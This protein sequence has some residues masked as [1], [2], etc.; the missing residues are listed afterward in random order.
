MCHISPKKH[1]KTKNNHLAPPIS[2][3]KNT[4]IHHGK[5]SKYIEIQPFTLLRLLFV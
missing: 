4:Y 2:V 1:L 3:H 5:T